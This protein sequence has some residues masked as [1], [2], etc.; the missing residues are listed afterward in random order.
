[1]FTRRAPTAHHHNK[2]ALVVGSFSLLAYMPDAHTRFGSLWS[3]TC[4]GIAVPIHVVTTNVLLGELKGS[5]KSGRSSRQDMALQ[6]KG[7]TI[8]N[9][10]RQ[11]KTNNTNDNPG[12]TRS[13]QSGRSRI[14]WKLKRKLRAGRPNAPARLPVTLSSSGGPCIGAPP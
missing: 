9:I 2:T 8:H 5:R 11:L 4:E 13:H 3:K 10:K 12:Q 7:K 14:A 1:M 6:D